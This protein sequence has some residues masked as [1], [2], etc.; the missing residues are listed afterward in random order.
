MENFAEVEAEDESDS[1]MEEKDESSRERSPL[2]R[3][4]GVKAG[5]GSREEVGRGFEAALDGVGVGLFHV[6]LIVVAGWALASDSVEV[7][8]ISFVTPQLSNQTSELASNATIQPDIIL[9]KVA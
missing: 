3:G 6:V 8:C 2:I 5:S 1:L 4:G 9:T 7:Q